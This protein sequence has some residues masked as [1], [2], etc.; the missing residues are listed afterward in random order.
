VR[1][2]RFRAWDVEQKKFLDDIQDEWGG[3]GDGGYPPFPFYIDN[4][5]FVMEQYTGLKDKN[6]KEIYEGDILEVYCG[7]DK[8]DIPYVVEDLRSFYKELDT[9]DRYLQ[10]NENSIK[11]IGNIHQ[12]PELVP[13]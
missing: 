6:G 8:Q 10:I 1:E 9:L 5:N 4:K 7:G 13:K 3:E 2:I 12:K 11:V